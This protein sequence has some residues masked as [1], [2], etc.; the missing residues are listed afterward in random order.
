MTTHS[1]PRPAFLGDAR[2]LIGIVLVIVSISG[3]WLLIA[4]ARQTTPVLQAER[5]IVR[6]SPLGAGDFTVVEVGLGSLSDDYLGP[7]DLQQ[8]MVAMRTLERG[9]LVPVSGV[10]DAD[11]TRT[12]SVVV[13]S[14]APVPAG[15]EDGSVVELWQ[16]PLAG[17]GRTFEAPRILVSDAIVAGLRT[18][19][20]VLGTGR[21]DVE[22]VVDR[23]TVAEVLAAITGGSALSVVPAGPGR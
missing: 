7:E 23:S 14:S 5:T 20:G 9:E 16:A 11:A 15:V 19:D 12:T 8:G 2:F 10:S 6:G 17:D 22:L 1:R 18:P 3:V 4:S 21:T 13:S